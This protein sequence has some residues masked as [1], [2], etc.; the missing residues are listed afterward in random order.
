MDRL[1]LKLHVAGHSIIEHEEA[2]DIVEYALAVGLISMICIAG[3]NDLASS[4]NGIFTKISHI[5]L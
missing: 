3:L 4:I 5:L 1:F 2:Q